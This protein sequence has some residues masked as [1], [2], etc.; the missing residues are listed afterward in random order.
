MQR[1]NSDIYIW[2][3]YVS[4]VVSCLSGVNDGFE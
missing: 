3:A 4:I 1:R 2:D